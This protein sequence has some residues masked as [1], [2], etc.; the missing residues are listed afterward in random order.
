MRRHKGTQ[1][2]ATSPASKE[3]RQMNAHG[4][5]LRL[6]RRGMLGALLAS[7]AL[8]GCALTAAP[9]MAEFGF[10]GVDQTYANE[11][12]TPATQA[13]SHPYEVTATVRMNYLGEPFEA[14]TDGDTKDNVVDLPPGFIGNATAYPRCATA[15]FTTYAVDGSSPNCPD[16][17][18]VGVVSAIIFA[19]IVYVPARVF[20]LEPPPGVVARLGFKVLGVPVTVDVRPRPSN[21]YNV[22]A[23][24][25][26]IPQLVPFYGGIL[27]LWG[28]PAD[29]AHDSLRGSCLLA[30]T[31]SIFEP[32]YISEGNC[33]T[34]TPEVPFL[35][36]PGSCVGPVPTV[37][38]ADSW[39][40]PGDFVEAISTSH[41]NAEPPNPQG[42]TGC[43]KLDFS[44]KIDSQPTADSAE[45]GSGLDF[46]LDFSDEGLTNKKGLAASATKKAVVTLPEGM[47]INPS[48]GEGL[49]VCTLADLDRETAD[50]KSGEGCPNS[51]KVGSLQVELPIVNEPLAGSIFLAQ[52]DDPKTTEP[53]A[54]NPFD[55]LIAL[56]FVIKNPNLSALAK[57]PVKVEPDPNTGQLVATL[58]DAPQF[59]IAHFNAHLREGQRAALVTPAAC[60]TYTTEAKLYPWSDPTNPRTTTS[61]FQI[62]SGKGDGPC[63]PGGIP[64]FHPSFE[65]G[66]I[67]NNAGSFSP[68]NMRLIREDGEQ[69]MT[70]FSSVL[71]PGVLGKLAGVSKCPDQAIEAA[72]AKT[73]RE[74][75]ASPSCPANSKIGRTLAGAGV[76]GALTFVPGQIYLGGPYKGA[77]LSVMAITPA[78]AGPFDAGTVVVREALT[79]NPVTA[80]VEVD[81]AA[82]DPIPHIL[83]GIVLK[84]RDLR[85]YVDRPEFILNPT[86]C[87][88]SSAK[89]TLFGGFLD[90]F[91]PADDVPVDLATRYQAANCLN[92]GFKPHLKLNLKGGTKRGDHPGLKA[93]L[94]ARPGDANIAGASVTLPRSAF[95]DQ[96]HIRTICTRVQYAAKQC[97]AGSIYGHAKAIT[98]LLD[99]PIEG[100]VYLRSS[101]NNLPDL[102]IALKGIVDVDVSS[103]ID[104]KNGGIRNTFD[105]VPDAPVKEFVLTLQGGKKGL[106]V[107][108]RDLC[109]GRK[110]RINARFLAQNGKAR[111]LRPELE[112]QC[113][114]RGRSG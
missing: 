103:R 33:P 90:V 98:P 64:P 106:I 94:R 79:L 51:S 9:A 41:D 61:S 54:E 99:E 1:K 105:V 31:V 110:A 49:G 19:P 22:S 25:S 88:P 44:P 57:L 81:G 47:T 2:T 101:S 35:T 75:L 20:N 5:G 109:E 76:G 17:T 83:K 78:V 11:D 37:F 74:E 18:A 96:A 70:K 113:G 108:S 85:V 104:S 36:L 112:P 46:N 86:S 93:V 10:E 87:D 56:Y 32:E 34:D 91:S 21:P 53:G 6:L 24:L 71:P 60:G 29:P 27:K 66:S 92:L 77:P 97:P 102:V 65:A 3:T 68:F 100:N 12:G 40:E 43:G 95:L 59:P 72:K 55:T 28:T 107:N 14:T 16:S 39:Q 13:G 26:N 4:K 50:S 63:P 80:E 67:N 8:L 38:K 89:A 69:D 42:F 73:G 82:S 58:D 23:A 7:L 114:G 30:Q 111:T 15:D 48:V 52:Q 45:S 84:V 62:T